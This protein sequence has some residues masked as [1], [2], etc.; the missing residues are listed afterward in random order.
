MRTRILV[1][2]GDINGIGP[3]IILKTLRNKSFIKKFELTV[4][5]PFSVLSYYAKRLK[6]SLSAD[7]FNILPVGSESVII[8][9][10]KITAESGFISGLAVK[11][12]IELCQAGEYDAIVTAPISKKALN[13]GGF[14]YD[15]HTEMLADL[16]K[17]KDVCMIMISD[18]IIIG[19]AT[20]HPP[21]RK[22]SALITK[23]L[24]KNKLTVC[25]KSAKRDLNIKK[26][27]IGVLG[28]NPHAGEGGLI[29]DEEIKTILPV[30]N[31]LN[32]MYKN[33]LCGPFSPD[34]YFASKAY[35]SFDMTFAMYHDQ[36]FIP[37]KMISGYS[38]VNFTGGLKFVR[39][40]PDHGTAFD[41]AG[42]NLASELSLIE[43]IKWA[44]KIFKNRKKLDD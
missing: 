1:T 30:I 3:E 13:L 23:K 12:A 28:L 21:V 6:I 17:A 4:L 9:P 27:E 19:F 11:T 35:K 43:A 40:S 22:V 5:S 26:P 2:I 32:R 31:N 33:F 15:G 25:Y 38:G 42:K 24:L 18:K 44:D 29:G 37:F 14:K 36:G 8:N 16:G 39:T 10:G 20:T 34:A 7:Y 41:I